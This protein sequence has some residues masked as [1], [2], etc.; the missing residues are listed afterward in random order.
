M[1]A[2]KY[3]GSNFVMVGGYKISKGTTEIKD[4]DF[5][6]L[7]KIKSFAARVTQRIFELPYGF[8]LVAPEKPKK[9]VEETDAHDESESDTP[10][11]GR[12]SVKASLKAINASE[13]LEFL[14]KIVDSDDRKNVTQAATDRI[15]YLN[16]KEKK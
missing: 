8:P 1:V 11:E 2:V 15:K 5:Y 9:E 14:N 10:V 16:S 12:L 7:M 4:E 3:N 13:D 6:R